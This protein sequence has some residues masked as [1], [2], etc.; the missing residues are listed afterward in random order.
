LRPEDYIFSIEFAAL[1]FSAAQFV[2]YAFKMEPFEKDWNYSNAER[3]FATYSTLPAGS[4]RFRVR[5][6]NAE[7]VWSSKEAVIEVVV[8]PP[9]WQKTW[10]IALILT[11][12]TASLIGFY[13]YRIVSVEK[14]N[15]KL[16]A[17]VQDRTAEVVAQNDKLLAF[18]Q[19]I[20]DSIE[21]A[22]SIQKAMLPRESALKRALPEHF[23]LYKPRNVVSGDFYWFAE[24]GDKLLIAVADCTGHGVPGAFMS[25]IGN[26]LINEMTKVLGITAPEIILLGL[27]KGI[28]SALNQAETGNTDGMDIGVCVLDNLTRTIQFA[29]AKIPLLMI[30]NGQAH[31]LK[32]NRN[33]VGGISTGSGEL[34]QKHELAVEQPTV[35]YLYS[36]GFQDQFG[37]KDGRKM[38]SVNFRNL[39]V[40]LHTE[41]MAKQHDLLQKHLTDWMGNHEQVDDILVFGFKW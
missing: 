34:F 41:P 12:I 8:L 19:D 2:R 10:F 33:S 1:D 37:G 14:A 22:R 31:L 3:A 5:S 27:D 9:L 13:R 40:E 24:I 20:T 30:S 35:F 4:Y 16:E 28:R 32:G 29:G 26:N 38:R 6:T 23:V 7:G 17:I 36:D 15:A 25:M 18:R 39:L 11:I 21:Y